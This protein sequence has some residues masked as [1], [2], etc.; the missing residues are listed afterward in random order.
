MLAWNRD[1]SDLPN[2]RIQRRLDRLW[3]GVSYPQLQKPDA[4]FADFADLADLTDFADVET[5][6]PAYGGDP[7]SS[8]QTARSA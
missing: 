5:G 6:E 8:L 7:V 2:S 3:L 1:M 4:D